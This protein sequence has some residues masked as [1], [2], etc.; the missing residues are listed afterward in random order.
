[1]SALFYFLMIIAIMV[2][3]FI[4]AWQLPNLSGLKSK[5]IRHAAKTNS[6]N[7]NPSTKAL[8]K[9]LI[10]LQSLLA[11]SDF[12]AVPSSYYITI[13]KAGKKYA[14]F[15]LDNKLNNH[16]RQ[17]NG[18]PIINFKHQ[19]TSKQL[20]QSLLEHQILVVH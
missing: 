6:T 19:P 9:L 14:I 5:Q 8:N 12:E 18:I 1:M 7:T 15:T 10:N 3:L 13:S 11:D 2:L 16:T 17:L 4:I 20:Q